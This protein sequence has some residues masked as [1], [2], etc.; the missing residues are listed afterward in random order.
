MAE[1]TFDNEGYYAEYHAYLHMTLRSATPIRASALRCALE[2]N[3]CLADHDDLKESSMLIQEVM[4]EPEFSGDDESS[5]HSIQE[6]MIFV[7]TS[8]RQA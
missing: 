7:S 3:S 8:S 5:N 2:R 1:T 4:Q 6:V